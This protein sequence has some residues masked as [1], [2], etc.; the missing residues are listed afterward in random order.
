MKQLLQNLVHPYSRYGLAIALNEAQISLEELTSEN[1]A[2][3]LARAIETGLENFRLMTDDNPETSEIL[4]FR[5]IKKEELFQNANLVQSIGLANK[6]IY[7]APPIIT[8]DS[9]AKNTFNSSISIVESLKTKS[10]I[11]SKISFSRSFAP[12]TAKINNG[13]SS[14]TPPKGTLFESACSAITTLTP[15]KPASL[16]NLS[17][18]EGKVE[19]RNVAIIP[20]LPLDELLDFIE[21]FQRMLIDSLKENILHATVKDERSY[22]R[23]KIFNGSYPFAPSEKAFGAGGLLAAIDN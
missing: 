13:V 22:L 1:V 14:Q 3:V 15:L 18:K 9:D 12:T 8:T 10:P 17:K 11:T 4:R 21:L 20:D 16:V 6:G 7:I 5:Y 23:P 19:F 2:E